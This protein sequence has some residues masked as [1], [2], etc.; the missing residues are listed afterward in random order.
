M[1]WDFF[2]FTWCFCIVHQPYLIII[3]SFHVPIILFEPMQFTPH[4]KWLWIILA[5]GCFALLRPSRMDTYFLFSVSARNKCE[6]RILSTQRLRLMTWHS[7]SHCH[8]HHPPQ[9]RIHCSASSSSPFFF[10][11]LVW[12]WWSLCFIF[13]NSQWLVYLSKSSLTGSTPFDHQYLLPRTCL[14]N[15]WHKHML[16]LSLLNNQCHGLVYHCSLIQSGWGVMG[17]WPWVC[18]TDHRS[19][20]SHQ[21]AQWR[22]PRFHTTVTPGP[23]L[24]RFPACTVTH[25]W[26]SANHP[27]HFSPA[28]SHF[29]HQTS[30]M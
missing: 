25:T 6:Q 26:C 23:P 1:L 3:L 19:P 30:L 12:L 7:F 8:C 28:G 20:V 11:S 14:F 5:T 24:F 27:P 21:I 22:S 29:D 4:Y 2:Y 10:G 15:T 16:H 9:S 17:Q 13:S 18:R